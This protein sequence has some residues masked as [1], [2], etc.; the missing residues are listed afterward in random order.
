MIFC[1]LLYLMQF[2][3]LPLHV[4]CS[5]I[6]I[7]KLISFILKSPE[8]LR[9]FQCSKSGLWLKICWCDVPSLSHHSTPHT[10]SCKT[11]KSRIF[12]VLVCGLTFLRSYTILKYLCVYPALVFRKEKSMFFQLES[13]ICPGKCLS[14]CLVLQTY[15]SM[16]FYINI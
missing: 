2:M 5:K 6:E 9:D 12:L 4:L 15:L 3:L 11:V 14:H 16:K 1:L 7:K 8:M 13:E 10:I